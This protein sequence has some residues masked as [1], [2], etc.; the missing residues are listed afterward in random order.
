MD[1]GLSDEQRQL[2]AS[3]TALFGDAASPS[4]VRAAEPLGFDPR[5]WNAVRDAGAVA[6]AVGEEDGGWGAAPLDLALVAEVQG[7]FIAPAPIVEAQVAARLLARLDTPP[8]AAVLAAALAG[9]RTVTLAVHPARDGVAALVPAGA[10]ADD[11]LVMDG[12]RLLLVRSPGGHAQA[13]NLGSMPLADLRLGPDAEP[14]ASGPVAAAAYEAALDEFL[15]LTAAAQVGVAARAVE[16]G[17]GYVKERRAFGVPIGSFQSIAH[18]LADSATAV[19]GA[20]LLSHEAAWAHDAEPERFAELA[21]MAFAF[22]TET[23]RD[24]TYRAL[25]FHGGYG[26]T[27]EYDIQLYYRRAR[28]WGAV[29]LEPRA[30]YRRAADRRYGA[31]QMGEQWTSA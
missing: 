14:L 20:R 24:A 23:A 27:D 30:A 12:D 9:G 29:C 11:A 4:R 2:V 19:D 28:A 18:A 1:V 21:A 25:H 13:G 3:F 26:F 16:I 17:V 15:L 22:A 10:V 5:L 31:A 7:R 8:A 6:M